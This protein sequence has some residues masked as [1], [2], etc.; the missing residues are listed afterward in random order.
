M[1]YLFTILMLLGYTLLQAQCA[2]I[3]VKNLEDDKL[4]S[5]ETINNTIVT[6]LD[7]DY[8]I[9]FQNSEEGVT[10]VVTT[11]GI[12]YSSIRPLEKDDG[13]MFIS[14]EGI[15][16]NYKFIY[17]S[18]KTKINNRSAYVNTV[19]LDLNALEWMANNDIRQIRM[20]NMVEKKMYPYSLDAQRREELMRTIRCFLKE[21]DPSKV[22]D[23][24]VSG[25]MSGLA[26]SKMTAPSSS[27]EEKTNKNVSAAE[28][29]ARSSGSPCDQLTD[30][31]EKA[32]KREL[33][34]RKDALRNEI[35]E[36]RAQNDEIKS[37]LAKDISRAKENAAT[38]QS[39][40]AQQVLD[41]RKRANIEIERTRA[42]VQKAI[43]NAKKT[44]STITEKAQLE[45]LAVKEKSQQKIQE[46]QQEEAQKVAQARASAAERVA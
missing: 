46:I 14:D 28:V 10:A 5:L 4:H 33:A 25:S 44:A 32:L 34:L 35:A 43:E 31:E 11:T 15:K 12:A 17:D 16:R 7:F 27:Q 37:R 29:V 40:I 1:R 20:V 41:A 36:I 30:E 2:N 23:R 38:T 8:S 3:F 22:R 19:Q 13:L 9:R 42:E 45:A 39:E 6:R 24:E 26:Q 18:E 21:L